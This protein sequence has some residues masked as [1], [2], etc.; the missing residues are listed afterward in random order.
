MKEKKSC[1]ITSVGLDHKEY[2]GSS[3]K[4][5]AKEKSGILGKK[6]GNFFLSK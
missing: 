3:I 5:I 2:L 1:I 6:Y 4:N